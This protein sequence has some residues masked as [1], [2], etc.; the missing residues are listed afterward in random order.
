MTHLR[1][2][3]V[4]L[5]PHQ[6]TKNLLVVPAALVF[7]KHLFEMDAVLRVGLALA[8]FC[9][10]SG[11]VYLVNDLADLERD[12][13]HPRKR[14]RPLASGALPLPTARV[15]AVLLFAAGLGAALSLGP[16]FL[17][18]SLGYVA[19]NVAYSFSLKN[20]VILDVL[21]VSLGFVLRAVAGALAIDV[22]FSSW[23]LVCT[24]LLA[25]FLSLA[26]RRHELILLDA[27][28]VD[29]RQIL[30]EYSPYLLDQ[31]IAV[32][33]ASCLTVYAFYTLA[34]ETV[35]K[36]QTERLALT[37]PFVIYGIFRY[38][39]LVHRREEGGSPSDILLTDRPLAA[40]VVL[41]GIAV[42]AI[43]YTAPGLP[44]PRGV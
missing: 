44:V 10:L 36:Y 42:V 8:V 29:H 11:A 24:I 15:A 12:R 4:S 32:V 26:K 28:A 1:A 25:L 19:L 21:A 5:R 27:S 20:V 2:L 31:M 37:I 6:W 33:T 39:Y 35:E 17:A 16:G 23:L 30:A 43:V 14:L 38:L 9:A 34:P 18:A 13:L 7:S 22:H 41:W 40:A 3:F